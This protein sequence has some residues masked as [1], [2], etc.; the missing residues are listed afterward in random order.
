MLPNISN[1]SLTQAM[2]PNTKPWIMCIGE[3]NREYYMNIYN[4]ITDVKPSYFKEYDKRI[5]EEINKPF[6]RA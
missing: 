1:K 5:N 4:K 2:L 3:N 6:R